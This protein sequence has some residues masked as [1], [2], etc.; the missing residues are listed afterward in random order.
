MMVGSGIPI[1]RR[2]RITQEGIETFR[3]EDVDRLQ[4]GG[5][6][7]GLRTKIGLLRSPRWV[8]WFQMMSLGHPTEIE[9]ETDGANA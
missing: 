7:T 2:V 8:S 9:T 6:I 5:R 3:T 1:R 4:A